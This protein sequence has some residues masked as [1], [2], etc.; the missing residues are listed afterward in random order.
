MKL[1]LI[2]YNIDGLPNTLDLNELHWI[3]KP[4]V[5][6]YKLIKKTTIITINDNPD[7][8]NDLIAIGKYLKE[9]DADIIGVQEDFNYHEEVMDSLNESYESGTPSRKFGLSHIFR[10]VECWSY[11]PLPR[12]KSDGVNIITKKANFEIINENIVPWDNSYGYISHANDLLTK[13]GFRHYTL[14][15]KDTFYLIDVYVL[16]MDADYHDP[17]LSEPSDVFKDVEAR[18]KQL[19]QLVRYIKNNK[20]CTHPIIIMGDMNSTPKYEWDRMNI[21]H[22]LINLIM[23]EEGLYIEEAEPEGFVD[24]DRIFIINNDKANYKIFCTDAKYDTNCGLSDHKPFIADMEI[25]VKNPY[26]PYSNDILN[27]K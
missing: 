2:T 7:R 15:I 10:D 17:Q 9:K 16:H 13:K 1:R 24:V 19:D 4:F 12:F 8:Q 21:L 25:I 20:T 3:F 18:E 26:E 27:E 11:F 22:H 23:K 5:W 14:K 6:L